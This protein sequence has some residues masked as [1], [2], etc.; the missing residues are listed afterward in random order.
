MSSEPEDMSQEYAPSSE[1]DTDSGEDTGSDSDYEMES[2]VGDSES[3]M[4][5]EHMENVLQDPLLHYVVLPRVLPQ[6]KHTELYTTE[7]DMLKMMIKTLDPIRLIP[8][9]T[10]QLFVRLQR[11]H[12]TS[13]TKN[14][15]EAIKI[16][17]PGGTL[18]MFVRNQNCAIMIHMPKDQ[19]NQN[20]NSR[21]VI[22]ASI[23]GSLHSSEIYNHDSDIEVGIFAVMNISFYSRCI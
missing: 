14:I 22:V 11:L 2:E 13:T 12:T 15:S 4:G 21:K 20:K 18:A 5:S 23:P 7:S 10:K 19:R 16:L 17:Q 3:E 8:M 6:E 1:S 9:P